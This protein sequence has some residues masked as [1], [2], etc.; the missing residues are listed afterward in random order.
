ME[1]NGLARWPHQVRAFDETLSAIQDGHKRIVVT[2]PTGSGKTRKMIDLINHYVSQQKRVRLY[3]NRRLLASQIRGVIESHGIHVGTLAA[4]HE[5]DHAAPVQVVMTQT[6][7]SRASRRV[8]QDVGRCDLA[9]VDE[10]HIQNGPTILA[11]LE[12]H[13][14]SGAATVSYTATPLDLENVDHL[15][16]AARMSDCFACG[17][18]VPVHSYSPDRPNLKHIRKYT[19]GQD[20]SEPD[21]VKAIMRPGVFGRVH[22]HALRLN[23]DMFGILLFGPDVAGSLFFAEQF[24]K[25]GITAAH[26]DGANVWLNGEWVGGDRDAARQ[27]VIDEWRNGYISVLANRFVLREG[28][29]VPEIRHIILATVFGAMTSYLQSIGRG[30]RAFP[31]KD[32]IILQDH[33]GNVERFL[34]PN[35]DREWFLGQTNH[36][37][38]GELA[39]RMRD[40]KT[41]QP[42][43]CPKCFAMRLSGPRCPRCGHEFTGHSRMVVEIDGQLREQKTPLH[44]PRRIKEKPD[45]AQRW[46]RYYFG[47]RRKGRTFNQQYAWFFHEEHY[48]PPRNLPLMPISDGDWFCHIPDV[49]RE[50]LIQACTRLFG[51]AS[52]VCGVCPGMRMKGIHE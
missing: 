26:I 8:I 34:S 1:E 23:P 44:A 20:F 3:T 30:M 31:G 29:N 4:G 9:I 45:S 48:W 19:V 22:E 24:W 6:E 38:V 43:T 37:M 49:P 46:Q 39:Q 40:R 2:S 42:I 32:S 17:A 7:A 11:I 27:Q 25:A 14:E 18:T 50:R 41:P 13:I 10:R 12:K 47:G 35:L 33:G 21:N 51:V 28:I 16:V 36:R 52:A 5:P 15:I